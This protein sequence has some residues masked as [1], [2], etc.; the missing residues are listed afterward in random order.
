[1]SMF[2]RTIAKTQASFGLRK[3]QPVRRAF[4][5]A[6]TQSAAKSAQPPVQ[7]SKGTQTQVQYNPN[8]EDLDEFDNNI[9]DAV[10]QYA[11]SRNP[12]PTQAAHAEK[13]AAPAAKPKEKKPFRP[14]SQRSTEDDLDILR[15]KMS[16]DNV[17]TRYAFLLYSTYKNDKAL[18][19]L[20]AD[21]DRLQKE[22]EKD[23][24]LAKL[25]D[26][27]LMTRNHKIASLQKILSAN[28]FGANIDAFLNVLVNHSR[29][30]DLSDIVADMKE[31][32]Q[33]VEKDIHLA[34]IVSAEPLTDKDRADIK[35]LLTDKFKPDGTLELS[36]EVDPSLGGGF[37]LFYEDKLHLDNSQ[38]TRSE[39]I[40]KQIENSVAAYFAKRD[41]QTRHQLES[42]K[43]SG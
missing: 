28:S 33:R 41:E 38:R 27:D 25:I 3:I 9:I 12:A 6:A 5:A 34:H 39:E 42:A 13:P 4:S 22:Y 17:P 8:S 15:A 37:E 20:D 16:F 32:R 21:I 1:M 40:S 18:D 31:I 10:L 19:K 2:L 36:E 43:I 35:K 7:A 26:D 11:D 14:S 30:S 24:E 29:L 23:G